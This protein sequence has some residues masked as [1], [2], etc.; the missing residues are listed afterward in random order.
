MAD[1]LDGNSEGDAYVWSDVGISTT[2][3]LLLN[4]SRRSESVY[5]LV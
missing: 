1:L 4:Q 5:F 3:R 2:S